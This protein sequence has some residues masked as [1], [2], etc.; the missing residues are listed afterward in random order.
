LGRAA[1]RN[2]FG[3][4][5]TGKIF[6]TAYSNVLTTAIVIFS[7]RNTFSAAIRM[8]L[9]APFRLFQYRHRCSTII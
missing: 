3:L 6:V 5:E 7:S 4:A 8:A 1:R 9:A 2:T